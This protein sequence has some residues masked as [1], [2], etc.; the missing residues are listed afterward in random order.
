MVLTGRL[1]S[2]GFIYYSEFINLFDALVVLISFIMLFFN[3]QAKALG[4]LRVLRLVKVVIEMKRAADLKKQ[5][6]RVIKEQKRQSAQFDTNAEIV[7]DILERAIEEHRDA[8]TLEFVEDLQW[9]IDTINKNKNTKTFQEFD[10]SR[11][12]SEEYKP[13]MDRISS[14]INLQKSVNY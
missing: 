5:I 7:A 8:M 14:K 1:V 13:W 3:N 2:L 6:E 11:F 4:I 10:V 9:V 12:R